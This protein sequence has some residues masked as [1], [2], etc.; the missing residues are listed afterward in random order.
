MWN[1]NLVKKKS[2][3]KYK[4]FSRKIA[5][6]QLLVRYHRLS[7]NFCVVSLINFVII[8]ISLLVHLHI[9]NLPAPHGGALRAVVGS[10]LQHCFSIHLSSFGHIRWIIAQN[11]RWCLF[12]AIIS[13]QIPHGYVLNEGRQP[14][15]RPKSSIYLVG[16]IFVMLQRG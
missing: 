10:Y 11:I 8:A 13:F 12:I 6:H 15:S 1:S 7:T 14:I 5:E 2:V 16:Q 9:D 4:D 3:W